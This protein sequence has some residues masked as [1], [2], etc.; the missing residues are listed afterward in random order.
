MNQLVRFFDIELAKSHQTTLERD[1]WIEAVLG[2]RLRFHA[3]SVEDVRTYWGGVYRRWAQLY[4]SDR[5]RSAMG[6]PH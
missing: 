2:A 4:D 6:R 5:W 3:S 1:A